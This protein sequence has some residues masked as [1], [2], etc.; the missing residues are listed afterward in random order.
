MKHQMEAIVYQFAD[1]D[2]HIKKDGI[3]VKGKWCAKNKISKLVE[4]AE[5][6]GDVN[7]DLLI[8]ATDN[9]IVN[10]AYKKVIGI[11]HGVSWDIVTYGVDNRI[12]NFIHILKDIVRI[13]VK[14]RRY[15]LCKNLVCVDYN[16][17]N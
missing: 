17:I 8:F 4:F 5:D 3:E 2:F 7:V 16:F 15:S 12:G 9:D 10:T 11:Q 13:A 1:K 14:L 6:D